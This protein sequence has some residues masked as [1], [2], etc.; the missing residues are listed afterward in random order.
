MET[1]AVGCHPDTE[2]V[3]EAIVVAELIVS[4]VIIDCSVVAG[5]LTVIIDED[6]DIIVEICSILV[7][8]LVLLL[9]AK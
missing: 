3:T 7:V 4:E 6:S 8:L 2:D 9:V 5:E 1:D